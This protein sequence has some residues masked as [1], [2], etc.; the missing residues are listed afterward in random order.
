MESESIIAIYDTDIFNNFAVISGVIQASNNGYYQFHNC[1]IYNN[2]ALSSS[3]S[4]VFDVAD[5]PIINS[6]S[7]HDNVIMSVSELEIELNDS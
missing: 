5:T 4:Q 7:I 2:V 1:S 6:S 3:V